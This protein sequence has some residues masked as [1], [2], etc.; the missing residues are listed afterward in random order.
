[1]KTSDFDYYLPERLIAQTPIE[2]RDR[3]RMLVYDRA[4]DVVQDRIFRDLPE[5][6][7][8]GD[9]LVIN[10]TKVIPAR[11]YG[12]R[13]GDEGDEGA[14]VEVLLLKRLDYTRWECIARPARKLL[15]GRKIKFSDDL[16]ATVLSTG[17]EGMRVI[18]FEFDGIFEDILDRVGNMPLPPYIHEKLK[19][20]SRY[21]TV[22][23]R[24]EGSAAAPTAGLHFT[25][26]LLKKIEDMG[27]VIAR[28][29]LHVGLGTFRP[30]KEETI[31]GHK[32]HSEYYEVTQQSADIINAAKREGRRVI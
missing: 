4:N 25:P 30:V 15:P 20:K 1:M 7:R 28:V 26:E 24:E 9:V 14:H 31:E 11:I 23:C 12:R 18:E 13:V 10:D 17:E 2:P 19:D 22:Y 27:V 6:L 29:L 5:F 3:S 32:M 21:Q 8:P 16:S